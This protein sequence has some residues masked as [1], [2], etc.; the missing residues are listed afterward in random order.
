[1]KRILKISGIVIASLIVLF[2]AVNVYLYKFYLKSADTGKVFNN[3]YA[4]N[5]TMVNFFIYTDGE[6]YIAFDAGLDESSV[7]SEMAKIGM[8]PLKVGYVFLTHS[9]SDH[10]GGIAAFKN[11]KVY[12]SKAEEPFITEKKLRKTIFGEKYNKLNAK[13]TTF[14]DRETIQAGK[15]K[16]K[17]VVNPGHTEGS[18]TFIINDSIM[19]T[20]DIINLKNGKADVLDMFNM[21]SPLAR[22]SIVMLGEMSGD[23]KILCTAHTGC[24]SDMKTVFGK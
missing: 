12:I 10:V 11:A 16:I 15:I 6:N 21:D 17:A 22:K 14:N 13:Y 7:K 19:I 9:D 4:V 5:A 18:T 8:D 24:S 20:G 3:L 1:M 2:L 23:I